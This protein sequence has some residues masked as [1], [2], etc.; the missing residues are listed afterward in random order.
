MLFD[1]SKIEILELKKEEDIQ[2]I[3]EEI[4]AYNFDQ[5]LDFE[6]LHFSITSNT[7]P[8]AQIHKMVGKGFHS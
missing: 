1:E 4:Q 7:N 6:N 2:I 8:T 5:N 3:N